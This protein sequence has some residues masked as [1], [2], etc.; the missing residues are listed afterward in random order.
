MKII[1]YGNYYSNLLE[2]RLM[3]LPNII[4]HH[5][6]KNL[7]KQVRF[8]EPDIIFILDP[9]C[10]YKSDIFY[11]VYVTNKRLT[12]QNCLT[13]YVNPI[14]E[15]QTS[16]IS[17]MEEVIDVIIKYA[18]DKRIG[19]FDFINPGS[20]NYDTQTRFKIDKSKNILK[21]NIPE[22]LTDCNEYYKLDYT[23]KVNIYIPT[24]YRFEKTQ[25]SLISL[26]ELA[27]RSKY[28][29]HV[30]V[31]D[32]NT[33]LPEMREWLKQFDTHFANENKGKAHIVNYLHRNARKCDYVFSIDSDM[34]SNSDDNI[35]DH[36]I[37][38]LEIELNIGVVSSNQFE[39]SQH[40]YKSHIKECKERVYK[41]GVSESSIGIAGGCICL[42]S[43]D[44]E[45]I[46]MYKEN[47][48]IYTGDDGI[49]MINVKRKLGKRTVISL[50]YGLVHPK[51]LD[52]K[53]E[54][55]QQWKMESFK[56]DNLKFL[57]E[58]Y[59]GSN[60]KGFYDN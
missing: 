9:T 57:D 26:H 47:H 37:N 22:E 2:L 33:Q 43:E 44:F 40:W 34:Y 4:I 31:G 5:C 20:L 49:L 38:V 24:Y 23:K 36:M 15:T 30:Y 32:N 55:Y 14:E 8:F 1:L 60:K 58:K 27:K 35:I 41:L 12:K 21:Y 3:T 59:T 50:D 53:E 28:D 48:D 54:E 45:K 25:K 46:G 6:K 10:N 42:R 17:I 7:E 11:Y 19:N 18:T 39:L 13:C 29:V 16:K 51:A 56:R 52:K